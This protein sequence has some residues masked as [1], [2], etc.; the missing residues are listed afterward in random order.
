MSNNPDLFSPSPMI[1]EYTV[2][3]ISTLVRN[4]LEQGLERVRVRGEIS[5]LSK[6]SS[7]HLYFDLK[8]S[9]AVL[10]V[11]CWRPVAARITFSVT[12]GI[13]VVVTGRMTTYP[14]RSRYQ[15]IVDNMDL[16]G[17]GALLLELLERKKK[18][19]VEGLFSQERKKKLPFL[20]RTVG[21][22]TS[23]TG[24]VIQDI[25]HRL[26]ERFP[27]RLLLWP[28]AVQGNMAA[29][30]VI[31]AIEGFNNLPL[32][33]GY[34]P[35][36]LVIARG[37]GSFE[38]LWPFNDERLVR[39]VAASSI[40]IISAIGH[41]TDT[42]LIDLAADYRAPTPTAAAEIIVPARQ[43]LLRQL[44]E[45]YV[46]LN[47]LF[48][49]NCDKGHILL[50]GLGRVFE[51]P[52]NLY[53]TQLQQLD[54]ID[55]RLNRAIKRFCSDKKQYFFAVADK[56]NYGA[57]QIRFVDQHYQQIGQRLRS[58]IGTFYHHRQQ[59]ASGISISQAA[60]WR[61][62]QA[63]DTLVLAEQQLKSNWNGRQNDSRVR[64]ATYAYQ[65]VSPLYLVNSLFNN[66]KAQ[67]RFKNYLYRQ[68]LQKK[69]QEFYITQEYVSVGRLQRMW[70][71]LDQRIDNLSSTLDGLSVSRLLKRGF[72]LAYDQAGGLLDDITKMLVGETVQL[73]FWNGTAEAIIKGKHP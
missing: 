73:Q 22:I 3:E 14:G 30:Q 4:R 1:R 46:R 56:L 61:F 40:P 19:D 21:L 35:D 6:Q 12:D 29:D 23:P 64:L 52:E 37:G 34:R 51:R 43:D 48:Q 24:A 55:E 59:Q 68:V 44:Q 10:N 18:L 38:D 57:S 54:E 26:Q 66:L 9:V 20:P 27:V 67:I 5:N 49:Q 36:V 65:L 71:E 15:L 16:A 8:D 11:A 60:V 50:T 42:T 41:E 62:Y 58:S 25:V 31:K 45:I 2:S 70:E 7:G 53:E 69:N 33:L 39:S 47:L 28:V 17:Q 13:Q 63:R 72:L 32:S